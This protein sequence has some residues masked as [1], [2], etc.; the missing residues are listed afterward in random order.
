MAPSPGTTTARTT[1]VAAGRRPAAAAYEFRVHFPPRL[2][3]A[4]VVGPTDPLSPSR[5]PQP[6]PPP[7]PT[8]E[9]PQPTPAVPPADPWATDIGRELAVDRTRIEAVLVQFRAAADELKR[10]HQARIEEWRRA[11]VELALTIA[12]RLLHQRVAAGEFPVEAMVREMAG[13]LG[14]DEPVTVR[15]NPADLELLERRLDGAPL[16]PGRDD[17]RLVPDPTLG[18]GECRVEGR[19]G[20]ML[21][22][23]AG[24]IQELR[25]Q[26]I[27]SLGHAGP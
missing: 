6:T 21:S 25:E 9:P 18:R 16:L 4:A 26:L 24:Q 13:Q 17:P 14:E 27:R 8:P 12:T 20:M 10:R 19:E 15:L 7:A 2:S 1:E 23:W 11:A 3:G 5:L 22:E